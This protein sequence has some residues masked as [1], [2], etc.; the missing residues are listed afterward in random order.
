[1][2]NIII[3]R[4]KEGNLFYSIFSLL[5]SIF[6]LLIIIFNINLSPLTY[7]FLKWILVSEILNSL[8]NII[9]FYPQE[10][11]NKLLILVFISFSDIFT[12]LL[13]LFFSYCSL[14]LIKETDRL[15]KSKVNIYII[16]SF[17]SSLIYCVI[18]FIIGLIEH[19]G[20]KKNNKNIDTIDMRF[21]NY[22]YKDSREDTNQFSK[23]FYFSSL[24]HSI[25]IILISFFTLTNIYEVLEF[26]K[27]K[28]KR[29]KV[30]SFQI[31]RLIKI[32]FRY[33]LICLSYWVFLIP[34]I[35]LVAICD[36]DNNTLR[37]IIYLFSDSFFCLR[38]FLI[39][40][41]TIRSS[42]LQKIFNKF[43]EVN[44]KHF[45]LLNFGILK[46]RKITQVKKEPEP[47]VLDD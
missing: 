30:N 24:I 7:T 46:N 10:K 33:A 3:E 4:I 11:E 18:F 20:N 25:C 8:G 36:K 37:D 12:N 27:E 16:I 41:N 42:K 34:R 40:L 17:V 19:L 44:I 32:L 6:L 26:M 45:L 14:K 39:C 47:L 43:F 9:Q 2:K 28:L 5:S 31:L 22:Y 21:S 35:L 15:I 38:G 13:F 23:V 1:M 29:D